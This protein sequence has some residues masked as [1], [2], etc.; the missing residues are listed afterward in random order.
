MSFVFSSASVVR[1]PIDSED[2]MV[3]MMNVEDKHSSL[4]KFFAKLHLFDELCNLFDTFLSNLTSPGNP[5]NLDRR[6][7][8]DDSDSSGRFVLSPHASRASWMIPAGPTGLIALTVMLVLVATGHE[9]WCL[10]CVPLWMDRILVGKVVLILLE[11]KDLLECEFVCDV[12]LLHH[13]CLAIS[14]RA[15]VG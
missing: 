15:L 8:S 2:A 7:S 9:T 12:G 10:W 5:G 11:V 13:S 4:L 14:N 1:L 6:D 3:V